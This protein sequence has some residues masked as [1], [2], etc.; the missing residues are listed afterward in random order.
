MSKAKPKLKKRGNSWEV[1]FGTVSRPDE[2][3]HRERRSFSTRAEA[4]E[5]LAIRGIESKNK[6]V[7]LLDLTDAQRRDILEGM[8]L[9]DGNGTVTQAVKFFL[10]H[11]NP[12]RGPRTLVDVTAEYISGKERAG[13]RPRTIIDARS[14]VER[15]VN[16]IDKKNIHEV[17]TADVEDWLNSQGFTPAT[18][19]S[20]RRAMIGLFNYAVKRKYIPENPALAIE[21]VAFDQAVPDVMDLADVRKILRTAEKHC[22]ELVPYLSIGFFAGLRTAELEGLQW[23]QIDLDER[24]ITVTPATAKKRRMRHLDIAENLLDWLQ[25]YW[26]PS[27]SVYY[28]RRDFRRVRELAGVDWARNVMRHSFASYAL[29]DTQ[30]AAKVSLM[31]GHQ[32]ADVLFS[33]YRNIRTLAGRNVTGK[34]AAE[35]WEIRPRKTAD[36]IIQLAAQQKSVSG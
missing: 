3:T 4:Q 6:R 14:K 27:G 32:R 12:D 5:E 36:N 10:R 29:A 24:I 11:G 21:T 7:R 17:M 16:T 20:Y 22:P 30:D 15:F 35:Y 23:E 9:L 1:D 25:P 8:E 26:N 33:N 34:L 31:L 2:T 18:R 28:S 19:S 13:R